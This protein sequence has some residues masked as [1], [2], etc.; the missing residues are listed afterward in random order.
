MCWIDEEP[1]RHRLNLF[2]LA[3]LSCL[4]LWHQQSR[5]RDEIKVQKEESA[6]AS[7]PRRFGLSDNLLM[8]NTTG[9]LKTNSHSHSWQKEHEESLPILALN[10]WGF[11]CRNPLE[12]TK[13]NFSYI[14][15][16]ALKYGFAFCASGRY[17]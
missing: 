1:H 16:H 7:K 9:K 8:G 2:L 13:C 12:G 17:R 14:S 5:H 15:T 11:G 10:L 6:H 4:G 3:T